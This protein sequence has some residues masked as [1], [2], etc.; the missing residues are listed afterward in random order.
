MNG[1]K[2]LTLD[3]FS[4][5]G[6]FSYALKGISKTVA[7]CEIDPA[8]QAV[9]KANMARRIIHKAPIF[10]DVTKLTKPALGIQ[11]ITAGFPCQDISVANPG[12]QGLKG[13]RSGLFR[14]I[15]RLIDSMPSI[16][17]VFLE[18]SSRI[19]KAGYKTLRN[20]MQRR[21]FEVK[22]TL[23]R[24][25]DVGALHKRLRWFCLCYKPGPGARRLIRQHKNTRLSGFKWAAAKRMA[26][27]KR[28][29][30]R[31]QK[32]ALV[33]RCKMLGNSIVPQ[34]ALCAWNTLAHAI[35][36]NS[37]DEYLPPM[38]ATSRPRARMGLVFTDGK[39]TIKKDMWA[40]PVHSV[41]HN[42]T[43][44]TER[45]SRL[46]SNQTFYFEG[47][48]PRSEYNQYTANPG[49]V[50]CLMGYPQGYTKI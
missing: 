47:R 15:L 11:M 44:L 38:V 5:I 4:G 37:K 12:G 43:R 28:I 46:L 9:L 32:A 49:F 35:R 26:K 41:W 36:T 10:D 17:L 27:V 22:Y 42:Y 45:G 21:G 31:H 33:E 3:L 14:E 6:G 13:K 23:V 8:C 34:A 29:T 18:N 19:L 39:K 7:Y 25:S 20:T 50:E 1:K 2:L 16:Q 48:I 24:A 40:T 30:G